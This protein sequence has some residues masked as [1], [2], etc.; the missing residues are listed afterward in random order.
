MGSR[1]KQVYYSGATGS[2]GIPS[3]VPIDTLVLEFNGFESM[4]IVA[5]L[6]NFQ[7]IVMQMLPAT[8]RLY[9]MY[10]ASITTNLQNNTTV[11]VGQGESYSSIVE[12]GFV[13][14]RA[15]AATTISLNIDHAAYSNIRRFINNGMRI[16][17]DAIRIEEMLNYFNFPL[18]GKQTES[19]RHGLQFAYQPTT[20]P[21]NPDNR[22]LF[23]QFRAP[24]I[25]L[26]AVPPSNLVFL[27][28]ISGSMDKPN[29]LPLLQSAF[30]MLVTNLREQDT[31]SLVT[32][33]GGIGV[34]LAP[35]GGMHKDII[36]KAIDSLRAGGDT[37]GSGAIQTA[38]DI[39]RHNFIPGG[40]NRVILATDGDFNVGQSSDKELE[41]LIV[42]YKQ[43]GIYLTCLGV[44]MGNYK[45]SKLETL[46]KRGNG[47][48]AYIDQ[49]REAEKVL[50]TEFT[51]NMYAVAN[52]A[53]IHL[54]FDPSTV[55]AY[56][57]IGFDN[58]KQALTEGNNTLEGG[59]V[60][61]G[62]QALAIVEIVPI[63]QK[64]VDEGHVIASVK[65]QY[66]TPGDSTQRTQTVTCQGPYIPIT[67]ADSIYRTAAA[68]S[69][70]GSVLRNSS[71]TQQY[72]LE[73]VYQLALTGAN[74]QDIVQQEFLQ[75]IDKAMQLYMP[76][77]K[78]RK[79]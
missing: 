78:K 9:D 53:S 29:R 5:D 71:F 8:A 54:Q 39:A 56:R 42:Q 32:Y 27:I 21:W 60:G 16:P 45:D 1:P 47:N 62:H 34:A 3:A 61:S 66:K 4:K 70:F 38:Y 12:N 74:K 23:L 17:A 2:F 49:L 11:T 30:K 26:E 14:T 46:A 77:R 19:S 44:G 65:L 69:L 68:I 79:Q 20:C 57:L 43:S 51:K 35:T 18:K 24:I 36:N 67:T 40:N 58:K 64:H 7:R 13:P 28:D 76:N 72:T 63:D 52:D 41:E 6:R 25:P 75:L 22:L 59:E 50:V 33:G 10:R 48:F 37:P 55:S 15:S 73:D 31:I